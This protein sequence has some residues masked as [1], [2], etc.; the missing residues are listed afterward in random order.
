MKY[1]NLIII[2]CAVL[3]FMMALT[4]YLNRVIFPQLVKKI[5][6]E[7]IEESL[8]RKVEI[9]SIHFNW[10]RGFI[11]DRIKIYEK[12]SDSIVFAQ[13]DQVSFGLLIF[14]DFKHFRVTIPFINVESPSVRLIRL[15]ENTWNFSDLLPSNGPSNQPAVATPPPTATKSKDNGSSFEMAWGGLTINDGNFLVEDVTR[16]TPWKEYFDNINLKLSLSYKNISYELTTDIPGKHG[17]IAAKVDYEPIS[18]NTHAWLHLKN[19]DTASYL[20]LIKVPGI[21][22]NSGTFED[23]NVDIYYSKDRTSVQGDIHMNNVD[24]SNATQSFKGDI[25][26]QHMNANYNQGSIIARG[27]MAINNM[28]TTVPNLDCGG[29]VQAKVLNFELSADNKVDFNGSIHAQKVFVQAQDRQIKFDETTVDNIQIK[30]DLKGIQSVGSIMTKGLLIQWPTQKLYGDLVLKNISLNMGNINDI[31]LAGDFESD[32]FSTNLGDKDFSAQH[33]SLG[34]A[35]INIEN[36]KN[37]YINTQ[38]SLDDMSLRLADSFISGSLITDKFVLSVEDNTLKASTSLSFSK[39]KFVLDHQKTIEAAPQ[40]ELNLQ[41]PL[42]QPQDLIYKGSITFSDASL[43]GFSPLQTLNHVELDADFENDAATINALGINIMN[44]NLHLNGTVK[45]FKDP[46]LD[47]TAEADELDLKEINHLFPKIMAPLGL[48][49]DGTS[50][51][52]V[53]F[54]GRAADPLGG[55]ILAVASFKRASAYSR[56]LHQ[57]I[58]NITGIIEATPNSLKWRDMTAVY[59][60]QKYDLSGSLEDF[61]NPKISASI[62]GPQLEIKADIVKDMDTVTL[63]EISGKFMSTSFNSLGTIHLT[64]G[65]PPQFDINLT[66]SLLLEELVKAL[67]PSQQKT[68]GTLNPTGVV[69]ISTEFKGTSNDWRND[70]AHMDI[71]SPLITLMGYKLNTMKISVDEGEG[72]IKNLIFDGKL[73]DGTVHAIGSMNL[74]NKSMPYDLALNIDNTD[75]H[76]LKMD[77]PLKMQEIDGKFFFTSMAHGTVA[78]FKNNLHATGSMAI[79]DG[80]LAEFNLF[81]GLLSVLNDALR[82]GQVEITDVES[83][84]IIDN[85]KISTDN[86][87]LKGP[88]IVLLGKGWVNFDQYCDLDMTVDLSSGIV[89]AIA[90][91]VLSTLN[92]RIYDKISDP[93]F[94]KKLSVPQVINSLIKNFLE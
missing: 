61:K 84:F 14:P 9:G 68:F 83:N 73:Y 24:I 5:A 21:N 23:I 7:R 55:N 77:S 93:K 27:E 94:K 19:I 38:L 85:Q 25:D 8:K 33:L 29:S 87:R 56:S 88:T 65:L 52:K 12:N 36:E 16:Q 37:L 26:I 71:S 79:R 4:F 15:G 91:D 35:K 43:Y 70:S 60:D 30:K 42:N 40:V 18:Q 49:F 57:K 11:I 63:N 59:N 22:V 13:A 58:K 10:F 67:P 72:R 50:M 89:P 45:N 3:F 75:M 82:L 51:V 74:L 2:P 76:E 48:S 66:A 92:I 80:F 39:G 86:L 6:I 69:N 46:W 78:D 47:I 31:S 81:K 20:A 54:I 64:P 53:K 28:E 62:N 41:L 44:T 34:N 17:L 90:H 32:N 1:R